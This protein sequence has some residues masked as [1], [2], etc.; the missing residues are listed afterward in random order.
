MTSINTD[1][2]NY[3]HTIWWRANDIGHYHT[4]QYFGGK[5][6]DLEKSAGGELYDFKFP[7]DRITEEKFNIDVEEDLRKRRE[8]DSISV[9]PDTRNSDISMCMKM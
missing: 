6:A 4:V 2:G 7:N 3:Y 8:L 5:F 1:I 9:I